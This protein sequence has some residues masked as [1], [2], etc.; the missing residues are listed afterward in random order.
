MHTQKANQKTKCWVG[1]VVHLT[2]TCLL[3]NTVHCW[4]RRIQT[5]LLSGGKGFS[6]RVCTWWATWEPAATNSRG[7]GKV[8]P[9][10]FW[11]LDIQFKESAVPL[12]RIASQHSSLLQSAADLVAR[13]LCCSCWLCEPHWQLLHV[14]GEGKAL[15]NPAGVITAE[16]GALSPMLAVSQPL[17]D[18][19]TGKG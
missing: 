16:S 3:Y 8:I 19:L 7:R 12:S 10:V 14:D 17:L 18:G 11:F 13:P 6:S 2:Y 5:D 4:T 9:L 1:P 15:R